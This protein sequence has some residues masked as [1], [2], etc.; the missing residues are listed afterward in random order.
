[1]R[2]VVGFG[3]VLALAVLAGCASFGGASKGPVVVDYYAG[4]TDLSGYPGMGV[5]AGNA[6]YDSVGG[7]VAFHY[8]PLE[9][10]QC[11]A[12]MSACS[13]GIVNL[14]SRVEILSVDANSAKV[15]VDLDYQ[16][17]AEGRREWP[18]TKVVETVTVPE[19]INDQGSRSRT[20]DIP[21]GEIRHVQL[22]HGVDFALCVSPPGV[23]NL[24]RRPCAAQLA[25]KNPTG[26]TAF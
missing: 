12:Q 3:A 4:T 21:Y 23:T 7:Q 26:A 16:V 15:R 8:Q 20:A 6:L 14:T 17:G 11:N 25:V 2:S 9:V 18:G 1:M 10:R 13:L 5:G 19:I 22:P 24:D